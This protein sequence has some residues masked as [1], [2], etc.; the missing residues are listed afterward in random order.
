MRKVECLLLLC[1]FVTATAAIGQDSETQA[2]GID[3]GD[4]QVALGRYT[5]GTGMR[6]FQ[7]LGSARFR[8]PP[9][10]FDEAV[11]T[12]SVIVRGYLVDILQGRA[13]QRSGVS[14][15]VPALNLSFLKI[16]PSNVLKGD[17]EDYYLVEVPATL[18]MVEELK[19]GRYSGELLL[20]LSPS[21]NWFDSPEITLWPDAQ[22]EWALGKPLYELTRPSMLFALT[23]TGRLASPLDASQ[24]LMDLYTN[25]NSL[26]GLEQHIVA[27]QADGPRQDAETAGGFRD[28]GETE[29]IDRVEPELKEGLNQYTYSN[30]QRRFE[31]NVV[32]G[33]LK[34]GRHWH[35]N[36]QLLMEATFDDGERIA[37]QAWTPDGAP[38]SCREARLWF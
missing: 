3:R 12:S 9:M 23:G 33:E 34:E 35:Q 36:G 13:I 29:P 15:T 2:R 8:Y 37:C 5:D 31:F 22:A 7:L 16:V 21:H 30:G 28:W 26:A 38:V 11:E 25:F 19:M 17:R 20:L 32:N 14:P 4:L 10:T 18:E 6:F 27:I 1:W 24:E